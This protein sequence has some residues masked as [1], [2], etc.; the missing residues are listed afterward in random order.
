MG[1]HESAERDCKAIAQLLGLSGSGIEQVRRTLSN[2]K[3]PW[4]LV[5]DNADNPEVDYSE[6]LP[7]FGGAVII[8]SRNPELKRYSTV[9]HFDLEGLDENDALHLF[10][11]SANLTLDSS[12]EPQAQ[13]LVIEALQCHPLAIIQAGAHIESGEATLEEYLR[14]FE[15][16]DGD[17]KI[18]QR[19]KEA[20][21]FFDKQEQSRYRSAY[22]TFEISAI[23]LE[24]PENSDALCLLEILATLHYS[25]LSTEFFESAWNNKDKYTKENSAEDDWKALTTWHME[26][27][28]TFISLESQ[29]DNKRGLRRAVKK[30]R[31]LALVKEASM[32]GV[33]HLSIH[34]LIHSWA[35]DRQV[36]SSR[37]SSWVQAGVLIAYSWHAYEFKSFYTQIQAHVQSFLREKVDAMFSR[38]TEKQIAPILLR[39]CWWL[40]RLRADR[41]LFDLLDRI[42]THMKADLE[43]PS[44]S[45]LPFHRAMGYS[46]YCLGNYSSAVSVLQRVLDQY[47]KGRPQDDY[48]VLGV[49]YELASAYLENRHIQQ[50]IKL[51]E[52]V[53][54]IQERT[55]NEHHPDRLA[56]QHELARA[57][58]ED[59]QTQQAIK[60]LETVISI[61]EQTLDKHHPDRLTSQHELARSYLWDGKLLEAIK[62]LESVVELKKGRDENDQSRLVSEWVLGHAYKRNGE[63][64]KAGKMYGR[65]YRTVRSSFPEGTPLRAKWEIDFEGIPNH[66]L[67]YDENDCDV[68]DVELD[69]E[70]EQG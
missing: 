13:A 39:C 69:G 34:P 46:M 62:I 40:Q 17:E 68:G 48:D 29:E 50:A 15:N 22:N 20:L 25:P 37:D 21:Q 26:R 58:L 60:L 6:Y 36:V 31:S 9:G 56:S 41:Q 32:N 4:L 44:I 28:P 27:F 35:R 64:R 23:A 30:L 47:E 57:Y 65:V 43:A 54:S 2:R 14:L 59:G 8:T 5:L 16:T 3:E 67:K 1:N 61:Q 53:I 63:E 19:R 66:L 38:G 49:Q 55:Q 42:F 18:I 11:I 51:L 7:P 10:F 70:G 45:L 33:E 12:T 52:T 24:R